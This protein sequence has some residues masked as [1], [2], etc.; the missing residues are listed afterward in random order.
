M[1]TL[2]IAR[3]KINDAKAVA[4][5]IAKAYPPFLEVR[6]DDDIIGNIA[7]VGF[8]INS[9]VMEYTKINSISR[10]G[11][12]IAGLEMNAVIDNSPTIICYM[13]NDQWAEMEVDKNWLIT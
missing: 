2:I 13:T 10:L 3:Y 8:N 5:K 4:L 9:I 6:I 7:N 11:S 12:I 1:T